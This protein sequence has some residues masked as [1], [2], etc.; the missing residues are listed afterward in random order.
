[1]KLKFQTKLNAA[2][3]E[4]NT[5]RATVPAKIIE[6]LELEKSDSLLWELDKPKD[7]WIVTVKKHK[8]EFNNK[9]E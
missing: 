1:M 4:G 9:V 5:L 2:K 7:E 6:A 3:K 8:T